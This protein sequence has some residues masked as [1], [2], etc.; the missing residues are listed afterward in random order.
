MFSLEE[1]VKIPSL[2]QL[3]LCRKQDLFAIADHFS[4]TINRQNHKAELKSRIIDQLVE[5]NVLLTSRVVMDETAGLLC[6]SDMAI[7][8]FNLGDVGSGRTNVEAEAE[9]EADAK[10]GLPPFDPLSPLSFDSRDDARQSSL[11]SSPL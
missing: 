11:G 9:A 1:F 2:E 6:P 7:A 8:S 4:L 5:L 10:A 3:N